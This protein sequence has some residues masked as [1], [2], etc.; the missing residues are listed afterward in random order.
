MGVVQGETRDW[1]E[2]FFKERAMEKREEGSGSG[3]VRKHRG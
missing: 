1:R 2:S 3:C